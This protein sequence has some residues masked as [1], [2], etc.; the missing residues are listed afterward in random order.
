MSQCRRMIRI[1]LY[2]S[3]IFYL[4]NMSP[5]KGMEMQFVLPNINTVK[6]FIEHFRLPWANNCRCQQ[7]NFGRR[8]VTFKF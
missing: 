2:L 5:G 7:H 6:I 1:Q 3:A 8:A 4:L